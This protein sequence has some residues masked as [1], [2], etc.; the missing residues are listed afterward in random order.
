MV[1]YW[2]KNAID[3]VLYLDDGYGMAQSFD[4]CEKQAKFVQKSLTE[5]GFLI[6]T[7]K[8]M[9]DPKQELEWLGILWN[10]RV[11]SISIPERRISDLLNSINSIFDFFPRISARQLAQVTGKIISLSPVFGVNDLCR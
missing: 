7:E 10:S 1:K 3:I 4:I 5:A 8:S 2:R 9:F 6:N 11:F